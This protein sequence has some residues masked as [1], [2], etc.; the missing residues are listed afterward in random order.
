MQI[1]AF[2]V[3][4]ESK[5]AVATLKGRTTREAIN[6]A[7]E[8]LRMGAEAVHIQ[9]PSGESYAVDRFTKEIDLQH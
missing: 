6:I 9:V 5:N 4:V 3:R 2:I 7:Q 8:Y 1:S